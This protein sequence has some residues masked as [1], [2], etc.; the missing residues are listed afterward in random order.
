MQTKYIFAVFRLFFRPPRPDWA[1]FC[2]EFAEGFAEARHRSRT[3]A[4]LE[5]LVLASGQVHH[6]AAGATFQ[7]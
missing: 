1:F 5:T 6:S 7:S 2:R 3:A 4:R